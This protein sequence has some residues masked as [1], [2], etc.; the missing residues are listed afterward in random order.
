M[1]IVTFNCSRAIVQIAC[2]EYIPEPSACKATTFLSGHAIAAPT[3][4]GSPSPIAPPVKESQS[5]GAAPCVSLKKLLP[6]VTDS[7]VT[8][9]CSGKYLQRTAPM[10]DGLSAPVGRSG[11]SRLLRSGAVFDE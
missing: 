1:H 11:R 5:C 9:A 6:V 2:N 4:S 3:A 7:S 8:I 10:L